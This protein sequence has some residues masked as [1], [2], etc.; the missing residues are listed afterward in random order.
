MNSTLHLI[1][2]RLDEATLGSLWRSRS[3]ADGLLLSGDAV[4]L[5]LQPAFR[6][7]AGTCAALACDVEA[8]GL[9]SLWPQSVVLVDHAGMV[10]L[11][12]HHARSLS[13]A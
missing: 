12:I 9:S 1:S 5:A 7:V 10:E 2:H 13:W 6:A 8:R 3:P 4:Y 11:C